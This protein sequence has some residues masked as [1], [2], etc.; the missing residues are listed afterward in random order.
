MVR[1]CKQ[2]GTDNLSAVAA[3][4]LLSASLSEKNDYCVTK[5]EVTPSDSRLFIGWT[6]VAI[7][8]RNKIFEKNKRADMQ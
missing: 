7:N 1:C 2:R 4:F 5:P 3:G 6:A 8:M